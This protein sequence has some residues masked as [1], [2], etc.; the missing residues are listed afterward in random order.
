MEYEDINSQEIITT[1]PIVKIPTSRY[2]EDSISY[3]PVVNVAVP[4]IIEGDVN[5]IN[6]P[7]EIGIEPFCN[8]CVEKPFDISNFY[9]DLDPSGYFTVN[10]LFSELID[11]YQ[12]SI[13][14]QNLGIADVYS[15]IW[16]NLSGNLSD[17]T[18]LYN[19]LTQKSNLNSPT[20]TG[21]PRVPLASSTEDSDIIA[22]TRWVNNRIS[23]LGTVTSTNLTYF[24]SSPTF[25]YI[26]DNA[27]TITLTW[28]YVNDVSSQ[29]INGISIS[30]NVRSYTINNVSTTTTFTLQY[31]YNGTIQFSKVTVSSIYPI[32]YGTSLTVLS[33]TNLNTITINSGT[34]DYIYIKINK[35]SDF[36]VNGFTGGFK[37]LKTETLLGT[38]YYTYQSVNYGLGNTT[39]LI[40]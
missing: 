25:R 33:K 12:R 37:L 28:E 11:N 7:A 38:T 22:S 29:S 27:T 34:T 40:S 1:N 21:A 31:T 32:Y 4:K 39:I 13:A 16:G 18:D 9:G 17:Q 14:R 2:V 3:I 30:S 15:Q 8:Q 20:F 35:Q 26:G 10:N 6:L 24:K 19:I 5:A 23:E 36:T